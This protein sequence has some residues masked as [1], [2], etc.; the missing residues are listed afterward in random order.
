MESGKISEED[1]FEEK[2]RQKILFKKQIDFSQ[3]NN[4]PLMLHI[5]SFENGDAHKDALEILDE[6][7]KE[8]DGKIRA[9]FHFYTETVN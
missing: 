8:F 5:R 2:I 6:K 3:K 4:L 9:N 1:F 7:Q